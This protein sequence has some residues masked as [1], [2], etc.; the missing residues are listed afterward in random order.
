MLH[1]GQRTAGPGE[2]ERIRRE[3][4]GAGMEKRALRRTM[5][6]ATMND[7]HDRAAHGAYEPGIG[8][9]SPFRHG[10][11][12][13]AGDKPKSPFSRYLNVG[14]APSLCRE[15]AAASCCTA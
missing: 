13:R 9:P 6:R 10:G 3:A 1:S 11:R 2:R 7:P 12:F 4:E 5:R 14:P 15:Q 8:G